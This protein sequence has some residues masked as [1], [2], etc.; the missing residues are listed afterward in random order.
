MWITTCHRFTSRAEFLAACLAA[1]WTCPPGQDPTPPG[2][3]LDILGPIVAPAQVVDGGGLISGEVLDPRY[4]VNLAW[5][6]RAPD[7]AF[8]ASLIKPA[9]PS[10]GW[11]VTTPPP[12]QPPVPPVI[13]AWKARVALREAGLLGAVEATVAA[14]GGRVQDAWV[15]ASEWSRDSAFLLTLAADLGLTDMDI[16]RLFLVAAGIR[17]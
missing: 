15:G 17:S 10:R 12:S 8:T 7:L 14:A 16:D 6:G 9:T 3:A 4:H 1:G 5:H 11:D 2:V 13:P